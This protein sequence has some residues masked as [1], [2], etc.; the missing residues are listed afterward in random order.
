MTPKDFKS[1]E[2]SRRTGSDTKMADSSLRKLRTKGEGPETLESK[3]NRANSEWQ[4]P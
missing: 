4:R 1:R 2:R 3:A